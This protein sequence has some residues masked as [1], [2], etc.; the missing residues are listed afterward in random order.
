ML[1]LIG[2]LLI[3]IALSLAIMAPRNL[4]DTWIGTAGLIVLFI[5]VSRNPFFAHYRVVDV[6]FQ[7]IDLLVQYVAPLFALIVGVFMIVYAI[8]LYRS[9]ANR[10]QLTIGLGIAVLLVAVG[11]FIYYL[12]F[13]GNYVEQLKWLRIPD[14]LVVYYFLLL[15]NFLINTVRLSLLE[16][17]S[18]QNYVIVLGGKIY[19]NGTPSDL[20]SNRLDTALSYL[21]RQR[22]LYQHTPTVIVS[23]ADTIKGVDITEAE[24]MAYY[25]MERGIPRDKL[26]LEERAQNTHD[27]FIY[28]KEILKSRHVNLETVH[29][30]YV[31]NAFHL[32]RSE[33]YSN[34]EGLYQFSGLGA[35]STL[36]QWLENGFREFVALIFM[37]RKFH[38]FMSLI[39][40]G[41][42]YFSYR[43][44]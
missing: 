1:Y 25:L 40:L 29:A 20:V 22:Y 10:L 37:H 31:T 21:N 30:I 38:F 11:L 19:P 43:W 15:I 44:I 42:R 33:I 34:M 8:T 32:Y 5:A 17:E 3:I 35:P 13:F 7:L 14:Y 24:V 27:N 9:E 36:R 2:V 6:L 26:I 16:D 41:L 4:W 18:R 23:G 12:A 28:T 39:L